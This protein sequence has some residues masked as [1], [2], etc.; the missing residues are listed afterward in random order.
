[1]AKQCP[2]VNDDHCGVCGQR[3]ELICCDHCPSSYHYSVRP[4]QCIG[5]TR[6]VGKDSKDGR[7]FCP[8]CLN[9]IKI[10]EKAAA[11]HW[12]D[13]KKTQMLAKIKHQRSVR[14]LHKLEYEDPLPELKKITDF[15]DES[16]EEDLEDYRLTRVGQQF[17]AFPPLHGELSRPNTD[18]YRVWEAGRL[19]PETIDTYFR[20]AQVKWGESYLRDIK[21]FN[22]Q[23]ACTILHMKN[24]DVEAALE[25]ILHERLPFVV[26]SDYERGSADQDLERLR[27]GLPLL[28]R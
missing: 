4:K 18:C 5:A 14:G 8:P 13:E 28:Q 7:W 25:A 27:Q 16:S 23:D 19:T 17:Q 24:Y 21:K 6:V 20:R 22:E 3:G 1:M 26:L 9:E 2:D 11:E 15:L 12:P 10:E